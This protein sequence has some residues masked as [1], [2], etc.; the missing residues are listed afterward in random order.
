MAEPLPE[1]G[2][3]ETPKGAIYVEAPDSQRF[4]RTYDE[5]RSRTLDPEQSARIIASL[6]E[7]LR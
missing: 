4:V 7:E 2:Y 3:A 6:A 5:L 1:V